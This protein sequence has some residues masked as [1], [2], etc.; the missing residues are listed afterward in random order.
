MA[1]TSKPPPGQAET[2][3]GNASDVISCQAGDYLELYVFTVPVMALQ[4]GAAGVYLT[5]V[6]VDQ[7]GPVGATGPQGPVGPVGGPQVAAR[8]YRA[9]AFTLTAAAYTKI[10]ID[11][12][13]YD[14]SA[15]VSTANGRWVAPAA[16]YYSVQGQVDFNLNVAGGGATVALIYKN[17][18]VITQG[19]AFG[20]SNAQSSEWGATVS[21]VVSL[22]AGDYLELWAYST[23]ALP[24][25]VATTR[26]YLTVTRVGSGA[27]GP[28]GPPGPGGAAA[29]VQRKAGT[30]AGYVT[31]AYNNNAGTIDD[32][33]GGRMQIVYTPSVPC[34]WEVT[35]QA[36]NV[37][38]LDA[39]YHYLYG[40]I[41]LTPADQDGIF[42]AYHIV[43]QHAQVNT[44]EGRMM[45]RLFRLAAGVTYTASLVLGQGNGGSWNYYADP[46]YL[47]IEGKAFVQ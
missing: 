35:A 16:G 9:A 12:V 32:G 10:P 7:A 28:Q 30:L 20:P 26:N 3:G 17:G 46:G 22:N 39:A 23:A 43:M 37:Q 2:F 38:K 36:G 25:Y 19:N 40:W 27:A 5:V 21:D 44:Y 18:A 15:A 33:S 14:T 11:T 42:Q 1:P 45:K 41:M 29:N 8:A 31:V 4:V 34:W 24:L 13:T 47:W 6:K